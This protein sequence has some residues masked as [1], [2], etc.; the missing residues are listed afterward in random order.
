[1]EER[2]RHPD[3]VARLKQILLVHNGIEYPDAVIQEAWEKY[4]E[5]MAAGWMMLYD[6]DNVNLMMIMEWIYGC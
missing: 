4:S 1:M 5:T 2:I 3:D 6:E